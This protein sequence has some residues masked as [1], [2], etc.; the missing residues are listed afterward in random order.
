MGEECVGWGG[1][2][3]K[4]LGT[5]RPGGGGEN[6]GVFPTDGGSGWGGAGRWGGGGGWGGVGGQLL[7]ELCCL[8]PSMQRRGY[9]H[10]LSPPSSL[11]PP[12]LSS[13]PWHL[14]LGAREHG[15]TSGGVHT[16]RGGGGGEGVHGFVFYS[17]LG[18]AQLH[19]IPR[20][21]PL[22][23]FPPPLSLF[24]LEPMPNLRDNKHTHTQCTRAR[25]HSHTHTLHPFS[26]PV[27][28]VAC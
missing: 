20:S 17:L 2:G 7:R 21:V 27:N 19:F 22:L 13:L 6:S 5:L 28:I 8:C 3:N 11:C 12:G 1:A 18:G 24:P 9:E 26:L 25:A 15:G 4:G 23:P 14:F 10:R 16:G